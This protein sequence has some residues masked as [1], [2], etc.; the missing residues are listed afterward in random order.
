MQKILNVLKDDGVLYFSVRKG[1]RNGR[2]NGRYYYDY[3]RDS[4]D[5]L[6]DSIPNIKVLDIWKTSDARGEDHNNRWY[7]V[8]LRKVKNKEE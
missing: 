6:L 8:L 1:D 4:L 3:S 5:D 2:Y 7:N